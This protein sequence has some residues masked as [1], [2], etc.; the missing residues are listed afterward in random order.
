[1]AK[2]GA[3]TKYSQE[4]ADRICEIISTSNRG[5]HKICAENPDLPKV[6]T[7]MRWLSEEDKKTF[8]EQYTR[9][10]ELQAEYLVD[11]ILDIAD[12]GTNDYMTIQKGDES[13][14]VEDREVT[15]RSKLRVEA[16]KWRASKLFPKRYGDKVEVD[17]K[18][19]STQKI[20]PEL[21]ADI[22][23]KIN[24]KSE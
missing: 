24:S 3:P 10:R 4:I 18:V 6:T 13:Y 9:A 1:M 17:A 5:L 2:A 16:R 7:I 15:N 19:E 22:A 21:I 20:S 8:R 12:D 11:E 14:N 23:K